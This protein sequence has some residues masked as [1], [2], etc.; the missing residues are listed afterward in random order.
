MKKFGLIIPLSSKTAFLYTSGPSIS[1]AKHIT[2]LVFPIP[3]GPASIMFGRFPIWAIA[4]HQ[5]FV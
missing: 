2:L 5:L 3:G 1:L 4:K